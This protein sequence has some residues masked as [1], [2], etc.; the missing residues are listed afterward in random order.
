MLQ[1]T[2]RSLFACRAFA[3]GTLVALASQAHASPIDFGPIDF[4]L[5]L[6]LLCL[7]AVAFLGY[8]SFRVSDPV[9]EQLAALKSNELPGFSALRIMSLGAFVLLAALTT[10]TTAPR[11]NSVLSERPTIA[12]PGNPAGRQLLEHAVLVQNTRT[13]WI[14]ARRASLSPP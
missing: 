10:T 13:G 4:G 1:P 5:I 2:I 7:V 8:R 14:G 9:E 3:V 6:Q 11:A 12:A